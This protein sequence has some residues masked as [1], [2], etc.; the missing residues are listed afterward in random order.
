MTNTSALMIRSMEED[1]IV[2]VLS[3]S[4]EVFGDGYMDGLSLY[5]ILSST[6]E[7]PLIAEVHGHTVGF[8]LGQIMHPAELSLLL[9]MRIPAT[10]KGTRDGLLKTIAVTRSAQGH[11]VGSALARTLLKQL[12]FRGARDAYA[13]AW[14]HGNTVPIRKTLESHGL[15]E[16]SR[17]PHY[18]REDSLEL[19]YTCVGCGE[20]PCTCLAVIFA[21]EAISDK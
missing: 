2:T 14:E 11:G 18:W 17:V 6:G 12:S 10:T 20:P 4:S 7:I 1:D 13:V 9:H 16:V 15:V 19:E 3:I 5:Y 21:M 8:A